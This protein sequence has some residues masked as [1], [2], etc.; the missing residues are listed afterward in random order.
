MQKNSTDDMTEG[1]LL[2]KII[3]Y[4]LPIIMTG[5]LQLLFNA[6]DL[7]VVGRYGSDTSVAAV[8]A[9]GSIITLITNLFIGLSVGAGV[10]VA[11]GLGAEK[12]DEVHKTVHTAI[13]IALV[14][15]VILTAVGV[16]GSRTFLE[17]MGTPDDVINLSAIYMKI[18]FAGITSSMVYNF[19]SAI[20]RAVGDTKSPLLYLT[21]AGVVNVILNLIFVILLKMDVAGVATATAVSQTVSAILILRALMKREDSCKL[22]LKKMRFYRNQILR[23]IQIGIPAGI[24]GSL[25]S[26]SNVIIQSSINSFGSV[27]M[28]GN[29][30]AGNI[31][32]FVYIS[33]NSFSQTAINFTAR[34]YGAG[35]IDRL[36][37]IMILCLASVFVTGLSLGCIARLFGENLLSIYIP[38]KPEDISYGLIRMTFICIPYFLCGLMDVTTGLLRGVGYSVLPMI[39]SVVGVCV[40]RIVWIYTVFRIPQYHTLQ[41]LYISYTISWSMTFITELV[42]FI[43]LLK[44]F[45]KQKI[46]LAE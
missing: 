12:P 15:G 1:P 13:P 30:A 11:H 33:M 27:V 37:K 43:V 7:V 42:I 23:I 22:T 38:G 45:R 35:K 2:K 34:N 20:L 21:V 29:A 10:L 16:F 26:I 39:I 40:F 36:R 8:G 3:L 14:S 6:A 25:F 41:S 32:G 44:K 9:T 17:L 4:T 28:S 19:G 18:Y 5:I 46:C 31:E 24:Q